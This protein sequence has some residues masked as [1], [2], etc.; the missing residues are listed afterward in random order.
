MIMCLL[1]IYYMLLGIDWIEGLGRL[2]HTYTYSVYASWYRVGRRDLGLEGLIEHV[3]I[4][5]WTLP[6]ATIYSNIVLDCIGFGWNYG[7]TICPTRGWP[8]SCW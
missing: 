4:G 3:C 2:E 7:E 8:L 1:A 6:V 5:L